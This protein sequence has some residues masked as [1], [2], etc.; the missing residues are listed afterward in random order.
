M[1]KIHL[2]IF[3]VS[4]L[5]IGALTGCQRSTSRSEPP[6]DWYRSGRTS[7]RDDPMNISVMFFGYNGPLTGLPL[8]APPIPT[9][10]FPVV[11]SVSG[12]AGFVDSEGLAPETVIL[13][14]GARTSD[15]HWATLEACRRHDAVAV[16]RLLK[17]EI[18]ALVDAAKSRDWFD[19]GTVLLRGYGE[20]APLVSS[21]EEA[22]TARITVG[23]PC[24][25][26]WRE[27]SSRSPL[28]ILL[29]DI[30]GG[31]SDNN[32]LNPVETCATQKRPADFGQG[33]VVRVKGKID[34]G[35]L[36]TSLVEA[37]NAAYR[38]AHVSR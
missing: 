23:E 2:I 10:T 15:Q 27:I 35:M 28:T 18:R 16:E 24:L 13:S 4:V 11:L 5:S 9:R 6:A 25:I 3:A 32:L 22:V 17:Q 36:P 34:S 26:E 7:P 20:A 14:A 30:P 19:Q 21:S 12:C 1:Q 8:S 31:L 38:A 33:K 29:T 37:R